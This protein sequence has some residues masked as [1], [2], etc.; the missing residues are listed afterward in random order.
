[1]KKIRK[2][3]KKENV[4][5]NQLINSAVGEKLSALMTVEYLKE[6]GELGSREKFEQVLSKIPSEEPDEKGQILT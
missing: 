3:A 6:R 1:M 2:L 5:M 4:S